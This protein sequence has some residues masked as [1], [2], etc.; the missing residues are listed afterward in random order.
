MAVRERIIFITLDGC[1]PVCDRNDSFPSRFSPFAIAL[2]PNPWTVS[3]N[4]DR[5]TLADALY[6]P[7]DTAGCA[8][9]IR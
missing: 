8:W 5:A 2:R 9:A 4:K 1:Q 7:L 6:P 3:S